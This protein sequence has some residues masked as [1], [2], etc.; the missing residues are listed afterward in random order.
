[1]KATVV[2]LDPQTLVPDQDIQEAVGEAISGRLRI[3]WE[4]VVWDFDVTQIIDDHGRNAHLT[5]YD[6][7]A[8]EKA[9]RIEY[10]GPDGTLGTIAPLNIEA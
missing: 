8:G 5:F 10:E 4:E 7:S 6:T 3:Q 9:L 2:T 1:M